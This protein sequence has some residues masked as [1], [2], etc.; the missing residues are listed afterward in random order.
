[1]VSGFFG[2]SPIWPFPFTAIVVRGAGPKPETA[3]IQKMII[4]AFYTILA[5]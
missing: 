2:Q 1:M 5:L 4:E 3:F